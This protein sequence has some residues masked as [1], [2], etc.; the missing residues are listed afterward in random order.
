MRLQHRARCSLLLPRVPLLSC[1]LLSLPQAVS[2]SPYACNMAP[3][4][5]GV[6]AA[7]TRCPSDGAVRCRTRSRIAVTRACCWLAVSSCVKHVV[8]SP[9]VARFA[10]RFAACHC[11]PATS[12][13]HL[14]PDLLLGCAEWGCSAAAGSE[15]GVAAAFITA[16]WDDGCGCTLLLADGHVS[17]CMGQRCSCPASSRPHVAAC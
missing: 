14:Q 6:T 2:R 12:H 16:C 8:Y 11:P 5:D 13:C 4:A 3:T 1:L 15:A 17:T 9:Q 7:T 10:A